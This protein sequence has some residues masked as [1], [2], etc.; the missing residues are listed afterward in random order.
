MKKK[1]SDQCSDAS[2]AKKKKS[3]QK[4][5]SIIPDYLLKQ[6]EELHQKEGAS[7]EILK[8]DQHNRQKSDELRK[9]RESKYKK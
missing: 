5:Q 3:V 1:D 7:S 6:V 2:S 9:Q 8:Q 4:S